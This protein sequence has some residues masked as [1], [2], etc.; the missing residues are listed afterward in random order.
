M[1]KYLVIS[2]LVGVVIGGL[3]VALFTSPVTAQRDKFD[4]IQCRK[5]EVVNADGRMRVVLDVHEDGG[6]VY[7]FGKDMKSVAALSTDEYGGTVKV[8]GKDG[9]P[10]AG[11][12][13]RKHGGRVSVQ[14][15][16][17]GMAVMAINEYG[18]GAMST[19]D[20]NGYRQ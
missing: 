12:S 10:K 1:K 4:T 18:N 8:Y 16:G 5:L 9:E 11:L 7:A 20:K 3:I 2:G 15:K 17:D 14:G 6:G 19:W 13:I